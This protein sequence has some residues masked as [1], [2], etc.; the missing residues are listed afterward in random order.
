MQRPAALIPI[1]LALGA[2]TLTPG[3]VRAQDSREEGPREIEKCQT[4]DKP[5]SYKL[6]NNITL[7]G[8]ASVCL[9][10]TTEEVTIDVAGFTIIGPDSSSTRTQAIRTMP[11][12]SAE[13]HGIAIRNGSISGFSAGVDLSGADGSIVE[14]LRVSGVAAVTGVG[15]NGVG[16]LKDSTVVGIGGGSG[17]GIAFTGPITG[18]YA[19]GN[20]G[21]G[22]IAGPGS[23]VIG[24]T[25]N[26]NGRGSD[27]GGGLFIICPSNVTNNTAVNN[28]GPFGNLFLDGTGCNN[29]NNV[30]P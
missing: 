4:I 26:N 29:T 18:N 13:L 10:I 5:G 15:I 9:T 25:A 16:I 20:D 23:S 12:T 1:A 14:R 22:I 3:L 30:A 24:N 19:A 27:G 7:P 2:I 17:V 11:P 8:G 6:V 28:T 21:P